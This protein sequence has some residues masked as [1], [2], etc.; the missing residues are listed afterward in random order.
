[1]QLPITDPHWYRNPE[2]ACLEPDPD[3]QA[4]RLA[5][6][7]ELSE[8]KS[9]AA[10][11]NAAEVIAE[12]CNVCPV[13]SDC[14]A[15]AM[16]REGDLTDSYRYG[17]QGGLTGPQRASLHRMLQRPIAHGTLRGFSAHRRR[18]EKPCDDCRA[19]RRAQDARRKEGAA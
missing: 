17:I 11:R 5:E 6:F 7:Y 9:A 4:D 15:D 16:N 19:A 2:R 14:L 1:M 12:F 8:G 3:L 18:N 10:R 13:K